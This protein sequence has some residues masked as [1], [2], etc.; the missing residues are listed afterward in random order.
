MFFSVSMWLLFFL[1]W[2]RA[3]TSRMK[4]WIFDDRQNETK[5]RQR[6]FFWYSID[7]VKWAMYPFC[8]TWKCCACWSRSRC[9]PWAE[10]GKSSTGMSQASSQHAGAVLITCMWEGRSMKIREEAEPDLGTDGDCFHLITL[11]P[12]WESVSL[13]GWAQNRQTNM[14]EKGGRKQKTNSSYCAVKF[15][16]VG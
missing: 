10:G 5:I 14:G 2:P 6:L 3:L 8:N 4:C 11:W 12:L 1:I 13:W 7:A 15:K 16:P 9:G